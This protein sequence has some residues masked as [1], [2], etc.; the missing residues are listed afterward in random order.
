MPNLMLQRAS[1]SGCINESTGV[2]SIIIWH[3]GE[4]EKCRDTERW[5]EIERNRGVEKWRE[6]RELEVGERGEENCQERE[7]GKNV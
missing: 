7:V 5:G 1:Q 3:C 6:T 2:A 4:S